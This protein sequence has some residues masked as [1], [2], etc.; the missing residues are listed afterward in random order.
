MDCMTQ[1]DFTDL[2]RNPPT[3]VRRWWLITI[4]ALYGVFM[5]VIGV[6]KIR[7]GHGLGWFLVGGGILM[8]S[9]YGLEYLLNRRRR[10][11]Q[12]RAR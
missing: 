9:G 11:S 3:R 12:P 1:P 4:A 2:V 7:G 8:V 6:L 5:L 10:G